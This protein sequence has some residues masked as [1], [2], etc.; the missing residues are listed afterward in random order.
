[1]SDG[2]AFSGFP[3]VARATAIPNIFFADVMCRLRQPG[4]LLAFLWVS[5]LV[6][7]Q[8][9]EARFVTADQV[10]GAHGADTSFEAM[11]GG[12]DGLNAGLAACAKLGVILALRIA[13]PGGEE[14]AYFVNNPGSRR[15][16]ARARAG[17]LRLKPD[18]VA[19]GV[20]PVDRP[21]I[22]R[23]YEDHI[24]TITPMV[25]E[26]LLHAAETYPPEW[27]EQ[28]FR[29]AAELNARHWR[30]IERI[31]I[32]WAEEGRAHEGTQGDSFEARK[33]R[34]LG[35]ELGHIGRHR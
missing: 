24:G 14:T 19:L 1:M 3:G 2:E 5:R 31:L 7:E 12:R 29:E 20:P 35:G 27:V 25:G 23:L 30:Y 32:R 17:E 15:A 13:G 9:A 6:Q 22:F 8:R 16:V 33:R 28:A 10:W 4:E 26:R 11:G 18:T 21:S 34:Y